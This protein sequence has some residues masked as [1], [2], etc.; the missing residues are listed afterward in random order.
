MPVAIKMYIGAHYA[1][2][3]NRIYHREEKTQAGQRRLIWNSK[4]SD[5]LLALRTTLSPF[6]SVIKKAILEVIVRKN[7][8]LIFPTLKETIN[9]SSAGRGREKQ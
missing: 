3:S 2:P 9:I 5:L 7:I 8:A 4:T 1:M 6:I